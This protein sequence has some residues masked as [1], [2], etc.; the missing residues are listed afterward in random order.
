MTSELDQA[1]LEVSHACHPWYWQHSLAE[2]LPAS[3]ALTQALGQAFLTQLSS[4]LLAWGE[5]WCACLQQH[6]V[7]LAR[8]GL[9][10]LPSTTELQ[11]EVLWQDEVAIAALNAEHRQQAKATDVLTFPLWAEVTPPKGLSQLPHLPLGSVVVCL[12]YAAT[13]PVVAQAMA[14][15]DTDHL[16]ALVLS[17]ALDRVTHGCLHLLGQHHAT[18][19]EFELV[20]AYQHQVVHQLGLPL[21]P[22]ATE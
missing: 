4:R 15:G 11:V 6:P 9:A 7:L 19:A 16:Q 3:H 12:P 17:Y 2:A 5:A 14:D 20:V 21:L 13:L 22:V 10:T 1:T 18:Q 8:L